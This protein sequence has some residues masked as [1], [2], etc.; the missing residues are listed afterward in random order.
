MNVLYLLGVRACNRERQHQ[1]E[2]CGESAPKAE[3]QAHASGAGEALLLP[4]I[5]IGMIAVAL[6]EAEAVVIQELEPADPLHAFPS[7]KVRNN[8]A[9]RSAMFGGEWFAIVVKGKEHVGPEQIRQWDVGGIVLIAKHEG[10]LR[11]R[12]RDDQFEDVRVQD[13]FPGIVQPAPT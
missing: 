3:I 13:A 11:L 10:E 4:R 8:Q 1:R 7:I 2:N 9:Q 5:T 12:L 6:P